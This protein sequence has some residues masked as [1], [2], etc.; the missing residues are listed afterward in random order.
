LF[1]VYGNVMEWCLDRL[2][3][4]SSKGEP[5]PD[6]EI[7]Q[8]PLSAVAPSLLTLR[9]SS[10]LDNHAG[11]RSAHRIYGSS[12]DRLSWEGFRVARTLR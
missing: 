5:L 9:G 3:Y 1:D 6:F 12:V 7:T 10:Y 8:G 11:C 4:G 2:F